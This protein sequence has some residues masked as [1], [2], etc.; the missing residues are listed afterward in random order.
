[1]TA[2]R[3]AGVDQRATILLQQVVERPPRLAPDPD[4]ILETGRGDQR[5]AGAAAL[6]HGIGGDGRSVHDI[7]PRP[8]GRDV[9]DAGD[10]RARRV[11]RRRPHLV[12]RD[13][14]GP[15]AHQVGERAAG[16]D[17]DPDVRHASPDRRRR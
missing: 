16:V 15:E 6:E 14:V 11:V 4:D 17:A 1:V 12:D 10:D 5:D 8:D 13:A 9:G 2:D 7:Q 3:Q